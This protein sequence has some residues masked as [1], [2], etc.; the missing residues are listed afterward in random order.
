[1]FCDESGGRLDH[2]PREWNHPSKRMED[3]APASNEIVPSRCVKCGNEWNATISHR[4]NSE[5]PTGC[6][7]CYT[8]HNRGRTRKPI[9]L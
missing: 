6:P 1:M 8:R 9:E 5:R 7:E 4:T 3:F 2:L